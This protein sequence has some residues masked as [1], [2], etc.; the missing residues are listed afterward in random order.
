[1][2]GPTLNQTNDT[3]FSIDVRS[4]LTWCSQTLGWRGKNMETHLREV[5][6]YEEALAVQHQREKAERQ[7]PQFIYHGYF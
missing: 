4:L 2:F 3:T 6:D 7:D 1:M 5:M